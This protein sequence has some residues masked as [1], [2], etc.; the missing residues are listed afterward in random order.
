[1][2]NF[3]AAF[4]YDFFIVPVKN[5]LVSDFTSAPTVDTA[6]PVDAAHSVAYS[7]G[8]FT[9][10]SI[11]FAMDGSDDAVRLSG[12]TSASLETDTGTEDI[13]TYD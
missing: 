2:A 13:Y 5:S 7:A 4:G 10:N 11:L 12:L 3:S 8:A 1:M 9:V 6:T